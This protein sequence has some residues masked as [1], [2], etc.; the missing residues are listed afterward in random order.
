VVPVTVL[1]G[2]LIGLLAAGVVAPAL[3]IA[4]I[5][6]VTAAR[7]RPGPVLRAEAAA[8]VRRRW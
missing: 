4:V 5:P 2:W 8:D 6:A 1:S 3:A 7:S